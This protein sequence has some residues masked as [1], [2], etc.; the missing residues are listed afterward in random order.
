MWKSRKKKSISELQ[1]VVVMKEVRK[2]GSVLLD[3]GTQK[4]NGDIRIE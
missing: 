3:V 2:S 1:R 4:G